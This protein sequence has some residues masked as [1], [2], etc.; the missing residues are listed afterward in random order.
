PRAAFQHAD[1]RLSLGASVAS[2]FGIQMQS[3]AVGWQV[4]DLTHRPLDLGFV[5]LAQFLPA[6]SLSLVAGQTADRYDRRGILRVCQLAQCLCV[7]LLWIETRAAVPS[8]APIYAALVLLGIARA[9]QAPAS[10]A[11]LPHLVPAEHFTNAVT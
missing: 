11:L 1:F 5:G 8:V 9:F 7:G 10:Q 2:V 6:I 4:Y 3:V